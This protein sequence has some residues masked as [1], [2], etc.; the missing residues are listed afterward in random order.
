MA[1]FIVRTEL[2]RAAEQNYN[3]LHQTMGSLGCARTIRS[4]QVRTY[5]LPNATYSYVGNM[6]RGELL[7]KAKAA[8]NST[9]CTSEVL[10]IESQGMTWDGLAEVTAHGSLYT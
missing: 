6:E 7:R 9:G 8:A 5:R 4:D 2:H 3:Q 1:Q 10:V